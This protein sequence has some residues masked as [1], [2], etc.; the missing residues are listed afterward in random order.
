MRQIPDVGQ[1]AVH[2]D[3]VAQL[4]VGKAERAALVQRHAQGYG[5]LAPGFLA[6][7]LDHLAQ[8]AAAV[9][10]R[11][12]V[13]VGP[14]VR[15]ARQEMLQDAEAMRTVKA[16]QVETGLLAAAKGVAE[17]PA[18]VADVF[19]VHRPG[20]HR[21][22]GEGE[23]R[24]AGDGQRH[25]ARIEVRAVDAG[26]GKLD[27]RQRPVRLHRLG[28][29]RKRGDVAVVPEMLFDEGGDFRTGVDLG[30]F[31]ED[32]APA[33][34]GLGT[35]HLDHGRGVAISAA[36]AVRHLVEA[37]LRHL[38]ADLHR[39]EQDVVAGIA[40]HFT[41]LRSAVWVESRAG[42]RGGTSATRRAGWSPARARTSPCGPT[43]WEPPT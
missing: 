35:A 17:P 10:Q 34:L 7:L 11:T 25:L 4:G 21:I 33:A 26:I 37:I 41:C 38:R 40:G 30:L 27:A 24:S 29:T 31:G 2:F 15:R 1:V 23:D 5:H 14:L 12:A 22:G 39:R 9:F 42:S 36:I 19:P 8:E 20:L 18:Q 13:F 6:R 16:D 28:H 3:E 43:I 32:H